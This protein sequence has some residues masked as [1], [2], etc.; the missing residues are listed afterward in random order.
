M[1]SLGMLGGSIVMSSAGSSCCTTSPPFS[2]AKGVNGRR[3]LSAAF[4]NLS[5]S[6]MGV[7]ECRAGLDVLAL[8]L[9]LERN[10]CR[11]CKRCQHE[12]DRLRFVAEHAE[13]GEGREAM[14][15]VDIPEHPGR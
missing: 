10:L 7:F 5:D 15:S 6:V 11:G 13:L 2:Q 14:L 8:A 9:A 3:W 12:F 4:S 1:T